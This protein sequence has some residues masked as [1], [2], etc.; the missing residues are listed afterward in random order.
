MLKAISVV[1]SF[2]QIKMLIKKKKM[3]IAF[4]DVH[5]RGWGGVG[6]GVGEW[7]VGWV[8]LQQYTRVTLKE[9]TRISH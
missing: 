1:A 9:A 7:D 8:G 2:N 4:R 3:K 5:F 6:W